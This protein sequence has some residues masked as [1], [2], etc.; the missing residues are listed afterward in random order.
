MSRH[1][2]IISKLSGLRRFPR[3]FEGIS[4]NRASASA[5]L[6]SRRKK[7]E[8]DG[9]DPA[10]LALPFSLQSSSLVRGAGNEAAIDEELAGA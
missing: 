6:A 1:I 9:G 10:I 8:G 7:M 2:K 3:D 4:P 5:A